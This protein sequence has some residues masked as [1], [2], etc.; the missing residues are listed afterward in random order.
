MQ[1]SHHVSHVLK[2]YSQLQSHPR[3][4]K[5]RDPIEANQSSSE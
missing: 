3:T 4:D 5:I 2:K 1:P